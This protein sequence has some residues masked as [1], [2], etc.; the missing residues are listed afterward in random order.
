ME[1]VKT[2]VYA[3]D[4]NMWHEYEKKMPQ[5]IFLRAYLDNNKRQEHVQTNLS[6]E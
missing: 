5:R 4:E 2:A 1:V 6:S 3:E